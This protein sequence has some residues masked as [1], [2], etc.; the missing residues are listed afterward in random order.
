MAT[1]RINVLIKGK[2]VMAFT[3]IIVGFGYMLLVKACPLSYKMFSKLAGE[4]PNMTYYCSFNHCK[5]VAGE[6]SKQLGPIRI[7]ALEVSKNRIVLW[8]RK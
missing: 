1:V 7:E 5:V 3:V 6:I 4:V 8:E 2:G